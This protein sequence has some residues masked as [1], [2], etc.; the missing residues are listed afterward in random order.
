MCLTYLSRSAHLWKTCCRSNPVLCCLMCPECCALCA[1]F[2]VL[3]C[4]VLFSVCY[5]LRADSCVLAV[6]C[7]LLGASGCGIVL[8]CSIGIANVLFSCICVQVTCPAL[9]TSAFYFG[10]SYSKMRVYSRQLKSALQPQETTFRSKR[11]LHV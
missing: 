8:C 6:L 1:D 2:C 10:M 7:C 3:C 5:A 4:A 11:M 9:P